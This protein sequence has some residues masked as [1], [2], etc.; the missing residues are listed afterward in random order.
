MGKKSRIVLGEG[1]IST[2][3]NAH[4]LSQSMCILVLSIILYTHRLY[5]TICLK[6]TTETF[7]ISDVN[8]H[9]PHNTIRN[10]LIIIHKVLKGAFF[11]V[12]EL[13][14]RIAPSAL[15]WGLQKIIFPNY[16]YISYILYYE[17]RTSLMTFDY[18]TLVLMGGLILSSF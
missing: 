14:N 4:F 13:L 18:S 15:L 12:I 16:F 17:D 6:T 7:C 8:C 10:L 11:W 1:G 5:C 3:K 2:T 9:P